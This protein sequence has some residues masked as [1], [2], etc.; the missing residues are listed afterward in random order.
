MTSWAKLQTFS[1]TRCRLPDLLPGE[2]TGLFA[3]H[4]SLRSLTLGSSIT[5]TVLDALLRDLP[6]SLTELSLECVDDVPGVPG[7]NLVITG[8]ATLG[9]RLE[10][11]ALTGP[12]LRSVQAGP[13]LL[14]MVKLRRLVLSLEMADQLP[15]SLAPFTHLAELDVRSGQD[16]GGRIE[17]YLV[18]S[19]SKSWMKAHSQL[20]RLSLS[21]AIW[22]EVGPS[23][24]Q[25][26]QDTAAR[27]SVQLVI[28]QTVATAAFTPTDH[29][30]HNP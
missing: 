9:D 2:C 22:N 11:L 3:R 16:L 13:I 30:S 10:R 25:S 24:Q 27:H 28:P 20:V 26:L 12:A 21:D 19:K 4:T 6:A 23:V 29:V 7:L 8:L 18:A 15:R 14:A 17:A 5:P 1:L